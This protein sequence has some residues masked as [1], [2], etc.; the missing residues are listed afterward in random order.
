MSTSRLPSLLIPAI[1]ALVA[2]GVLLSLGVWQLERKI[3]KEDLVAQI[4]ARAYGQ[5]GEIPPETSWGEWSRAAQEYRRVRVAGVF[6]HEHETPVH[7]LM[8]ATRGQPV[9]GFYL[10]TPLRLSNGSVVVV[11]RGF[12]PTPLRDP[13]RRPESLAAGDVTVTG[14]V[15][16]P[17]VRARFVPENDAA[18]EQWFVRDAAAIAA[19]RGLTR[20]A[21]FLIDA[22]ATPNP[23][24]WPKG[25]QTRLA[26]PNDHLAYAVTWFGIAG[27][28]IAVFVAFAWRRMRP[29]VP[30]VTGEVDPVA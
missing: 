4:E 5:P 23:G 10:L 22:D 9:Q 25:G 27:T 16:A 28:L 20:V 29:L 14:L 26:L 1:A 15:R 8:A 24:D 19:A 3:W 12:V 7:G 11:N 18:R 6:L 2:L 13:T 30:P 21:P 17:E